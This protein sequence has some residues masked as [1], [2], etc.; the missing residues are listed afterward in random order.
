[1]LH[2]LVQKHHPFVVL[3]GNTYYFRYALPL[4][5]RKLGPTLP[6]EV[7][8]SLS[9]DSFTEAVS[10]VGAKFPL[11]KLLRRCQDASVIQSLLGRLVDFSAQ[12]KDWVDE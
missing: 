7:K 2:K 3:R 1:M 9:T 6:A 11:I 4:H 5:L 12:L 8:R 10:M